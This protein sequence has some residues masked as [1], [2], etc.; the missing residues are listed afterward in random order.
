MKT[1]IIITRKGDKV[2]AKHFDSVTE[3][4][5][6]FKPLKSGGDFDS[7]ELWTSSNGRVRRI[8]NGGGKVNLEAANRKFYGE[9]KEDE[10]KTPV[11]KAAKKAAK[12]AGA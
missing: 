2:E 1:A 3:A 7:V 5:Q 6:E 11:K 10:V 12:K 4:R 9:P 8:K